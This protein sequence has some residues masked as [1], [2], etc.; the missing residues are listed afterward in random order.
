MGPEEDRSGAVT[1]HYSI[2]DVRRSYTPD[3]RWSELE[4]DLP[5]FLIYR[6]VSILLTPPALFLGLSPFAVTT[7]GL[8]VALLLPV[9]ASLGGSL[10][11]LWVGGLAIVNH[12]LDCLDGNIARTTGRSSRVGALYDGFCDLAF[13][14]LYFLAIGILVQMSGRGLMAEHAVALALGLAILV[15]LH[16]ELRDSYALT[17]YS[18]PEWSPRP[19]AHLSLLDL[20]RIGLIALERFYAFGLFV[21]GWLGRLDLVLVFIAV[22]VVFIFAA[23]VWITFAAALHAERQGKTANLSLPVRTERDGGKSI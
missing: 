10:A 16:R 15:L 1:R 6:P 8:V 2:A 7:L 3:K 4:G 17:F 23:A 11:Y 9:T 14:V 19:P 20:A 21:G 22:Y 18:R 12:V 13:W 5:S